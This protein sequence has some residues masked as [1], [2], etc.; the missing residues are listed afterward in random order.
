[1]NCTF[2][3]ID[4]LILNKKFE[5]GLKNNLYEEFKFGH[6]YVPVYDIKYSWLSMAVALIISQKDCRGKYSKYLHL[7]L[8]FNKIEKYL[9]ESVSLLSLSNE[10]LLLS[11]Y[12]LLFQSLSYILKDESEKDIL[13]DEESANRL[14]DLLKSNSPNDKQDYFEKTSILEYFCILSL[15]DENSDHLTK[16]F[17]SLQEFYPSEEICVGENIFLN[18]G[19]ILTRKGVLF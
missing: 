18:L 14:I 4:K 12:Y 3:L 6:N 9:N 5:F 13:I 8:R 11:I 10:N 1:M 7:K 2:F 16:I 15:V 17:Y 19:I